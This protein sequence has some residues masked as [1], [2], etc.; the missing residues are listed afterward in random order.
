MTG[1]RSNTGINDLLSFTDN[2]KKNKRN[3]QMRR[4]KEKR[5]TEVR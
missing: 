1:I 2:E 5:G 4:R 3:R